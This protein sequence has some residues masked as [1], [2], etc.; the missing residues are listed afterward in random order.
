LK[1]DQTVNPLI[2]CSR[3]FW[4]Y[5]RPRLLNSSLFFRKKLGFTVK[6]AFSL[7]LP[8]IKTMAYV[9]PRSSATIAGLEGKSVLLAGGNG[10]ISQCI[11][12]LL[13]VQAKIT[14]I[15]PYKEFTNSSCKLIKG[16]QASGNIT[17]INRAV[18]INSDIRASLY[19]FVA[20]CMDNQS[21]ARYIRFLNVF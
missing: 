17:Y 10:N 9:H 14:V 18:S 16:H 1:L 19:K 3:S 6:I 11:A 7:F 13:R 15:C 12:E 8:I 20:V 2:L 4:C 5:P 21:Q